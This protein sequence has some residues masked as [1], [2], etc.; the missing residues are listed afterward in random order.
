MQIDY[1]KK[2]TRGKSISYF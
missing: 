2:E 1:R